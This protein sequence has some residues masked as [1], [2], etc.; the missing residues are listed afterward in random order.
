[1]Y[2]ILPA[3]VCFHISAIMNI[4][5][6]NIDVQVSMWTYVLI[7]LGIYLELELLGH[8]YSNYLTF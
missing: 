8:T 7:L 6:V 2:H 4:T 1:M 3:G 5:S